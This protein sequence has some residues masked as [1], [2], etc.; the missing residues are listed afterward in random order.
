MDISAD[1]Y[2][3]CDE[4]QLLEQLNTNPN[5]LTQ[6]EADKRL[7]EGG[8]NKLNSS[9]KRNEWELFFNQ[10][11]SPITIIL[12]GSSILSFFLGEHVDAV[13]ILIIILISAALGFYQENGAANAVSR[14]L[15]LVRVETRVLRD[16]KEYSIP[17]EQVVPG[18]IV[19]LSAGNMVP[20]DCRLLEAKD[21][22]ANEA[23]L[24]GETFPTEKKCSILQGPVRIA[25][26]KNVVFMGTN[27]V[28]GTAKAVIVRT[29]TNTEFGSISQQ[30][31]RLQPE[32]EFE[33]GIRRFGYLLMEITL[34]LVI[35]IFSINIF[36]HKP[37]LDSFL[38]SL[39]IAVG[40]TPQL[41]PAIISI[42]LSKGA[43]NM[44]K[45]KV[46]VKRLSSIE[47]LGSMNVLCSD[48]TGTLTEG[49][50]SL[51][52]TIDC[53]GNE[54]EKVLR[55]AFLNASFESGFNNPIDQAIRDHCE[56]SIDDVKKLDELPY[57]FIRKCL[58]ILVSDSSGNYIITKGAFEQVLAKCSQTK[59]EDD[60][61]RPLAEKKEMLMQ[62]YKSYGE[63]GYRILGIAYKPV[64]AGT[65]KMEKENENEMILLGMLL[66]TDPL[67]SDAASTL[68]QLKQL[69]I[70]LKIITGD[71]MLVA[72]HI[73]KE[74][75]IENPAILSGTQMRMMSAEAL[76]AQAV[77]TD[78][79]AAVEPNQKERILIALKKKGNVV[80]FI[81][82]G[83]NDATALH[84]ADVGISVSGAVDVAK[85]AA[86][87]VL[88]GNDLQVLIN[89]I[90]E[91]RKTFANS[92]K[93]IFM[94]TSANFGNMFSMAGSSLFLSFLPLL[95]K[96]VLLTNLLTDIPEMT[97]ATD[98]VDSFM[99]SQPR[100][101]NISFIKKFMILFGIISSLFDYITFGVLLYG[102]HAS[103]DEFRTGWFIE[104]VVSAS[105]IVLIV[106][107]SAVFYK[108]KPGK[109]L[110]IATFMIVLFT[111]ILPYT[112]FAGI[113]GLVPLPLSFYF[114]LFLII[115]LYALAAETAKRFFYRKVQIR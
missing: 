21:L 65:K 97:I 2:Y 74:L 100:R 17:V 109:Y 90:K 75:G 107:T 110:M 31:K 40:L 37:A 14:L 113:M 94:A 4:A 85:E 38:F 45:Q 73:S 96:Q 78:V 98:S 77:H 91:G 48:K 32:T 83:I 106:R 26:R 88:L 93:Y 103:V 3:Q 53:Q 86:D 62:W 44:A 25:E 24:T 76:F 79:F 57:D 70:S 52:K 112:P 102:L 6:E 49:K 28:S 89:G 80:G 81:G 95:P 55:M 5:G 20:G 43:S 18:D 92:L 15:E 33:R 47:N 34:L 42:N 30:L 58:S 68:L 67:K 115:V 8:L 13:I 84:T 111:I 9:K 41:L 105:I 69:G 39:A 46:I 114:W 66:F 71:N 63:E 50:V 29:G 54:N 56:F 59:N 82:D 16:G 60:Q 12:I 64:D 72:G 61:L 104:S 108:S 27:I 23:T 35:I 11:K 22:F 10:F 99:I 51:Y 87:I 1:S 7:K 36:L 101:M 19:L